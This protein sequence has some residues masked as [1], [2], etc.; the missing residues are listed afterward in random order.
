MKI[1]IIG[2]S[3]FA[4]NVYSLLK[5]DGHEIVAV[6]TI[7]DL[8]N[9]E[10]AL[11]T[12]ASQDA[13]PV[14]KLSRW[15]LKGKPIES[16]LE[17]YKKLGAELNVLPYCSQ[18]IPMEVIEYPKHKSIIYH[19][20][21]LPLHRGASS[22][23]WT[24]IN[25]DKETG[26]TVF[27]A[28]DGLD[29]GPILLQ[30]R[31][32]VDID[33]TVE[34][35]YN[36][37]LF[38]QGV[39]GVRDAVRQIANGTA[40][41]IEQDNEL[42]TYEAMLNKEQ[43]T[44]IDFKS[45]TRQQI[46]NFIRGM[47]KVPGATAIL[48][49]EKVKLFSSSLYDGPI[50]YGKE[51]TVDGMSRPGI[52]S[53]EGLILFA[54]DAGKV[55]VRKIQLSSGKMITASNYGKEDV[56][57]DVTLTQEE[58][59]Q[60]KNAINRIWAS[61]L[62]I[63]IEEETNFFTSGASSMDVTRMIEE[64]K[65]RVKLDTL[66][67]DDI[68][69]APIFADFIKITVLKKRG[70][71]LQS[72]LVFDEVKVN[73]SE[74]KSVTFP[75]Q[76]FVNNEFVNSSSGSKLPTYNPHDESLITEVECATEQDVDRAVWAAKTAFETGEWSKISAR[77][78]GNILMKLA[79]LMEK[80]KEEL[81]MIES[82]D[83]GAVYTL[84]IKTHIGMSIETFRYFAGCCDK[85]E[86][87]VI[88]ISHARPNKNL[89]IKKREPIG[90][91]G[92][93][94]PWNY[95]LMMVAWKSAACLAAGNTLVLKPAQVSPLTALKLAQLTVEAGF[96]PGVFNVLPGTGSKCGQLLVDHPLVR[97]IGFTGSTPIGKLIMKS[98]GE[99]NVK[100]V[101]LELGGKSPLIIFSDF[102]IDLA[103]KH[104]MSSVF[105]NKGENCI[106]AGRIFVEQSIHD[107]F[108]RKVISE[109]SKLK[110]GNPLDRSTSHGPQN[111]RAHFE[112]LLEYIQIGID[113]GAKL[114]YGGK[115]VGDTGLYLEPT[116]FT[117][118]TDD[119]YIA[120][121][122]SFGPIMIISTFPDGDVTGV[123]KRANATEYGLASGVLTRDINKALKVADSIQ[124]GTCFVNCYNKTDVAAPF[125]GHKQSGFGKDLGQDALNEYLVT[126]TITIE[127]C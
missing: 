95:P 79:D 119:M 85:I 121:E 4:A 35:L 75:R 56:T 25:G 2:Q 90:V 84:A 70:V 92:L 45:K 29:E 105:F 97:K 8:N 125:G 89:T 48:N 26:F 36:K 30:R 116:I 31:F 76:I 124:A 22:I 1:A 81:A 40:P 68:Y 38:P 114:L 13:V 98:C 5:E 54:S 122:E 110:I 102:E 109:T 103:V 66:V 108:V 12:V 43:L 87:S 100:K 72:P 126:K 46:H 120:K 28:N 107:L 80:N 83:S 51:V 21:L 55:V 7:P 37:Y 69:M 88:P 3:V 11:A 52:I 118:V 101:S 93:I 96:P 34:T 20:S 53:Y 18:F 99:S 61:I 57:D 50:P 73:I 9:R 33:D 27:W 65:D 91:C 111:H 58:N 82:M 23:N 104:A 19:P 127:Y 39:I 41:R 49:G 44:L 64:V 117:D 60:I 74:E 10:D 16:V 32:P 106:A 63:E 86:G 112:K 62:L 6:Y 113:E 94:T 59:E 123:V 77:E 115:R 78:R 47:D 14:F 17:E 71:S 15:R 24:L 42:A 67:T